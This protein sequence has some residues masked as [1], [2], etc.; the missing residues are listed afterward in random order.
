MI[1][2]Y[3]KWFFSEYAYI[4]CQNKLKLYSSTDFTPIGWFF[5]KKLNKNSKTKFS[6]IFE[7]A[8]LGF[9]FSTLFE[10]PYL[11]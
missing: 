10:G 1:E 8:F 3:L 11:N 7:K 6:T 2:N 9:L 4:L 5:E